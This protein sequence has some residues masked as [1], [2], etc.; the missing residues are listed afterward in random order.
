MGTSGMTSN[1]AE[2]DREA[3]EGAARKA[4]LKTCGEAATITLGLKGRQT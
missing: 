4:A 2:G 1:G 3:V